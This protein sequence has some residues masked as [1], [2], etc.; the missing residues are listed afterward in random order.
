MVVSLQ[1]LEHFPMGAYA[2]HC[3]C[4]IRQ[5]TE[6]ELFDEKILLFLFAVD[7]KHFLPIINADLSYAEA[8]IKRYYFAEGFVPV[9]VA[10]L[11]LKEVGM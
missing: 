5:K 3:D 6:F 4:P 9:E 1:H 7:L 11:M 8:I 2:V 10:V